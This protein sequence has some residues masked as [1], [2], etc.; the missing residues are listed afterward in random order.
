MNV[1]SEGRGSLLQRSHQRRNSDIAAKPR[2]ILTQDQAVEIFMLKPPALDSKSRKSSHRVAQKYNVS[3]K[4]VRDIWTGRTWHAETKHLDPCR[5]ARKSGPPGR[6]LGKKD[7]APRRVMH[8]RAIGVMNAAR[9]IAPEDLDPFHDDWP[10]WARAKNFSGVS[11][12]PI[13]VYTPLWRAES[14]H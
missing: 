9:A 2:A 11:L 4:T 7:R 12:P 6:P 5:P 3:E 10:Y 13:I 1:E 14:G 8:T